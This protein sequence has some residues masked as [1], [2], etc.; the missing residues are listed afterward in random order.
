MHLPRPKGFLDGE[1]AQRPGS[2]KK[3]CEF[4]GCEFASEHLCVHFFG[5]FRR[6]IYIYIYFYIHIFYVYMYKITDVIS[7]AQHLF[8]C[9]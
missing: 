3:R 8:V 2:K 7:C 6:Y 1:M 9:V 5:K 4:L